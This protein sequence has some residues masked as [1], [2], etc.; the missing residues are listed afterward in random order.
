MVQAGEKEAVDPCEHSAVEIHQTASCLP[1]YI[2]NSVA[3]ACVFR[4]GRC[5]WRAPF[6]FTVIVR[7]VVFHF[8]LQDLL[9]DELASNLHRDPFKSISN[10]SNFGFEFMCPAPVEAGLERAARACVPLSVPR[11]RAWRPQR[12]LRAGIQIK[13]R[14]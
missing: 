7:W 13:D 14:R 11:R 10:D 2:S 9:W 12:L 4:K 6:G 8:F 3:R 1:V 5:A